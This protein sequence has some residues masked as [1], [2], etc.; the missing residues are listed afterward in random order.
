MV[1]DVSTLVPIVAY[2]LL[3]ALLVRRRRQITGRIDWRRTC[4]YALG[5]LAIVVA[6]DSKL[7]ELAD[8]GSMTAHMVQHELLGNIA[9]VLL[10]LGLDA[11]LARPVTQAVFGP[12]IR[13]P[14]WRRALRT[15]NSPVL[16]LEKISASMPLALNSFKC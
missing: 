8:A 4:A 10:L 1:I 9:P 2:G 16:S 15:A 7:D 6:L 5:L 11:A 13:R 3:Y 14:E 12:M